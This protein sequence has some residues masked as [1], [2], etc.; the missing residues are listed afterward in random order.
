MSSDD[1]FDMTELPE[2]M[3]VLG[4]GYIGVELA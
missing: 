2:S 3:V 1:F 4:G